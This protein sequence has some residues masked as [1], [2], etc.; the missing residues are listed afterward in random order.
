VAPSRQGANS[1]LPQRRS[2]GQYCFAK[3]IYTTSL[4]PATPSGI[5]REILLLTLK[6]SLERLT[7]LFET[8]SRVNVAARSNQGKELLRPVAI[9]REREALLWVAEGKNDWE[10]DESL[11]NSWDSSDKHVRFAGAK[12]RAGDRSCRRSILITKKCFS[13]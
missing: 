1:K 12:R 5:N 7:G 8:I 9:K 11:K 6:L 13:S 10:I 4:E 2:G 3:E